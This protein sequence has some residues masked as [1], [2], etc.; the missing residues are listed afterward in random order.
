MGIIHKTLKRYF[1]KLTNQETNKYGLSIN[2]DMTHLLEDILII[3]AIEDEKE[4]TKFKRY[5]TAENN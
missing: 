3:I 4:S 2:D 1:E 5:I